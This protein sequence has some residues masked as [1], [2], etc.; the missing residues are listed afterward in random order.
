MYWMELPQKSEGAEAIMKD[1][2]VP[3]LAWEA[4]HWS[5]CLPLSWLLGLLSREPLAPHK[6][7]SFGS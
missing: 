7:S 1:D 3:S 6:F 4:G 5:P 2:W